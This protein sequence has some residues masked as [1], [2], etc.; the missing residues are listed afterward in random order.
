MKRVYSFNEGSKEQKGLLGGK[1]ANLSE[2]TQL[3]LPVPKGFTLTTEACMEYIENNYQLLKDLKEEIISHLKKLEQA[4]GKFFQKDDN[5][6]LL[7]VRSGAKISMPGMMDTILNLGLTDS[8]VEIF[9]QVTG[10]E[11]FA[12]DC[13]RRL[14]QMYGN[15]V[16][17]I[18]G[19]LFENELEKVKNQ[20]AY[21][22][23]IQLQANDLKE[24]VS[25]YKSIYHQQTGEEFPQNPVDQLFGAVEAVFSSWNNERAIVYRN[26][27]DIPHHLGTAVNI[28][29]MVFGN[30]GN[31]S[32][33]GVAF[34]RNPASGENQLFGE[35]LLNAQGEDVVAGVRTPQDIQTLKNSL[36][37]VYEEFKNMSK[38]LEAHYRDLQDIEFTIEQ[39]KL[40]LLQTRSGK[41]TAKAA[42][43]IAVDLVEEGLASKEEAI[44]QID[45]KFIDHLLHPQFSAQGLSK[46]Q[47]ISDGGLPASPGAA[48]GYISFDANDAKE[49]ASAGQRV[50]LVRRET[51]PED[52]EGMAVAE[53]IVTSTGGMTSHAAV[54]ARGMGKCCVAGCGDLIINEEEKTVRY[55]NGGILK[56]GDLISVDGSNGALYLGEVPVVP[57]QAGIEFERVMEWAR[58]IAEL[59]IRVNAETSSDLQVGMEFQAQGVG[60]ARTEHM[61]FGEAELVEMRRFILSDSEAERKA[62]VKRILPYQKERFKKIFSISKEQGTVI[63]LLDPPLHEFTPHSKKEIEQVAQQLG[64]SPKVITDTIQELKEVNPMLG[65]R[66][67]RLG[68]TYPELYLMQVEG[69][70][71][72]A[73]DYFHEGVHL[74]PEIMVP[75][76][77]IDQEFLQLKNKLKK[78]I[79]S[80]LQEAQVEVAYTIG[81]M[82]EIPRACYIADQLA[83][84]SEFFSFGTND[85]TQLTYGFSRDDAAKF[86]PGYQQKEIL[87]FDP[88]QTIDIDGVGQL[89]K[90]AVEKARQVK[91]NFKIGVCGELGGDPKSIEFFHQIGLNYVSCSPLRVPVA[92]IAAAQSAIKY[93]KL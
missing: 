79:D 68:N 12:Y 64:K 49:K 91:P 66:G 71:K 56:E 2:M 70:I 76:V 42:F 26:L 92:Q 14:I 27:N 89:V 10:D 41:R 1:G 34:S 86:I 17:G 78:H 7:S 37:E 72:T 39:G 43:K 53:A 5:L 58:Q 36:P 75:L 52:I 15:V 67:C 40:Y 32:G 93:G 3:S 81:T 16:R 13:Y 83:K 35:Y 55:A 61:F 21:A 48:I 57:G 88:F 77:G 31:D 29:E 24:L 11:R 46:D 54:V 19:S 62:A 28:Q 84:E 50:V 87:D 20:N 65:H 30:L 90:L 18:N 82:I 60:L 69:I 85:L 80:I 25:L 33:T 47:L 6:L 44:L 59:D 73:I 4:T 9:A 74:H 45:S 51:S 38:K 22:S 8:R 63:R 23:D